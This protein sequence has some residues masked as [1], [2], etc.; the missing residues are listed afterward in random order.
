MQITAIR[1][2]RRY[3]GDRLFRTTKPHKL[4]DPEARPLIAVRLNVLARKNIGRIADFPREPRG[5]LSD[6]PL[7]RAT[8]HDVGSAVASASERQ[9]K[10]FRTTRKADVAYVVSREI[11]GCEQRRILL[12]NDG[13]LDMARPMKTTAARLKSI[14]AFGRPVTASL[15]GSKAPADR[16]GVELVCRAR[17][18]WILTLSR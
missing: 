11:A 4:L 6:P 12:I 5:S 7:S 9:R 1:G 2:A 18:A 13:N 10:Q 8:I 16:P 14:C 17:Q 15:N 3:F